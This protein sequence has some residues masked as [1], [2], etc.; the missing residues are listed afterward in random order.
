MLTLDR[1][2]VIPALVEDPQEF[3]IVSGLGGAAWDVARLT[4][5][6]DY[7]YIL[8]GAM[9]AAVSVGLGLALAQPL[10]KVLVITGEGELLMNVGALAT[11]HVQAPTNFSILVL[12]NERY[13]LTGGQA[14]HTGY[15]TDLA[16]M[17]E[18]AGLK[19]VW[20]VRT[21]ADIPRGREV[22]LDDTTPSLVVVKI[23]A[24]VGPS[25]PI[26]RDASYNRVRFRKA[27]FASLA[28]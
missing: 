14:G 7:A 6:G 3:L 18:G 11:V 25:T 19:S 15:G 5:E 28:T 4:E 26:E 17:A 1:H 21:E 23:K 20:T 27:L 10:R 16:K 12:D 9:G 22:L 24:D 13:G 2:T 8:D